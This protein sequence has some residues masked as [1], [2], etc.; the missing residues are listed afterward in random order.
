MSGGSHRTA[1][2]HGRNETRALR[3]MPTAEIKSGTLTKSRVE[4][5]QIAIAQI[6]KSRRSEK[7]P[8]CWAFAS[9]AAK[10]QILVIER[11]QPKLTFPDHGSKFPA[12]FVHEVL[13]TH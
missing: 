12:R 10:I 8:L 11:G 5:E 6:R 3:L 13:L 1:T 7:L 9:G 2:A 4:I